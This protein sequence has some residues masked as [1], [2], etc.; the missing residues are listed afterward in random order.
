MAFSPD[1]DDSSYQIHADFFIN[2]QTQD[3]DYYEDLFTPDTDSQSFV[4]NSDLDSDVEEFP[5]TF[6]FD[7]LP[8]VADIHLSTERSS[9]SL[10]KI[11]PFAPSRHSLSTSSSLEN[12]DPA[13][14][15][16]ISF[17]SPIHDSSRL[18]NELPPLS[19]WL[20]AEEVN[21]LLLSNPSLPPPSTPKKQTDVN[22]DT[23][24][25]SAIKLATY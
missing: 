8:Q 19:S 9:N 17:E 11:I 23:I 20:D 3:R 18:G 14:F 15:R 16:D 24:A 7:N 2:L 22:E 5:T 10:Q 12:T 25:Y 1:S 13:L 4:S 21:K 6:Y